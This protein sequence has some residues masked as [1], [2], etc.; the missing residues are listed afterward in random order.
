MEYA[1]SVS[2]RAW[3]D[4]DRIFEWIAKRSPEGAI[5]W[6]LAFDAALVELEINANLG[7]APESAD[8]KAVIRQKL[9][10]TRRGRRY[11]LLFTVVGEEVHVLRV[12]GP[13]QAPLTADD[14]VD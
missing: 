8:V 7:V 9:F 6:H 3:S 13:G 12:R 2:E 1:V 5:K 10:K 4:A 11:R 14:L